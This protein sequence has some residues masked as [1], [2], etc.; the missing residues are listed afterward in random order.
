MLPEFSPLWL[1]K[2]RKVIKHEPST[3]FF[4]ILHVEI[5]S[6]HTGFLRCFGFGSLPLGM[7]AVPVRFR[8]GNK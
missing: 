3:L 5:L 6:I 2:N 4:L 1:F 8:Q 7:H